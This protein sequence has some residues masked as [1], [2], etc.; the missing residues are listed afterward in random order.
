MSTKKTPHTETELIDIFKQDNI[1]EKYFLKFLSYY[2]VCFDE[3]FEDN[4]DWDDEDFEDE[5]SLQASALWLTKK[6]IKSYLEL[7]AAGHGEEWAHAMADSA[8]DGE[9][10]VYFVHFNLM[11][12]NPELAEKELLIHCKSLNNDEFFERHYLY[13]FKVMSEPND[14]IQTA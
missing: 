11:R 7:I 5:E 14:R 8:E 4:E 1:N 13:L 10:K 3:L 6:Y 12:V 9:R 2:K